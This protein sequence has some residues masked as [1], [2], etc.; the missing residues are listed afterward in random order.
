MAKKENMKK[1]CRVREKEEGKNKE[2]SKRCSYSVIILPNKQLKSIN[3]KNEVSN[4]FESK[5]PYAQDSREVYY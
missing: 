2:K 4:D 1:E 3:S 5:L